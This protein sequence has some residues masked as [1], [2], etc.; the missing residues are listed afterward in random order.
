MR[1]RD[2]IIELTAEI[3][4]AHVGRN[5]VST[6]DIAPL[7]TNVHATLGSL[8]RSGAEKASRLRNSPDFITCL[9]CG[10]RHR[11]LRRHLAASHGMSPDRYRKLHS[12]PSNYS[13]SASAYSETRRTI[14]KKHG[15]GSR[16]KESRPSAGN[17]PNDAHDR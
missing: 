17:R 14:A 9:V 10:K 15:L 16:R 5:P 3:V 13:L 6:E 4:A 2:R 7:I 1:Q 8:D 12:L 11:T